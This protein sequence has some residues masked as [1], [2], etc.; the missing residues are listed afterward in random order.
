MILHQQILQPETGPREPWLALHVESLTLALC[1][2]R[3]HA[4]HITAIHIIPP[5]SCVT[6]LNDLVPFLCADEVS[7]DIRRHI[8]G[9]TTRTI[10]QSPISN[11]KSQIPDLP[12]YLLVNSLDGTTPAILHT[13]DPVALYF[14]DPITSTLSPAE[15]FRSTVD[16][17]V[18]GWA[19]WWE[20]A[21][22]AY[23][24][25]TIEFCQEAGI[26]IPKPIVDS[27]RYL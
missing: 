8:A 3:G 16:L 1:E 7:R 22:R 11:L 24:K 17:S 9:A 19:Y 15:H 12:P 18:E 20:D 23:H 27:V 25:L 26:P 14:A 10:Q 2:Q 13:A 6:S 21:Q 4:I 5:P